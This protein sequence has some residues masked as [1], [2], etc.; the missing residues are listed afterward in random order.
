M[1]QLVYVIL[2][3]MFPFYAHSQTEIGIEFQLYPTGLIPGLRVDQ[4]ISDRTAMHLRLGYQI[5]DHRDL[6]VQDDET[7]SGYGLSIGTNHY[8]S[9]SREKWF[10]GLRA[11]LWL[12]SIDWINEDPVNTASGTTDITVLQPTALAGYRIPIGQQGFITPSIAFGFEWNVKTEGEPTGEG[13]ILL[14]GIHGGL[15]L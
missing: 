6:G 11:D 3:M 10:W 2:L 15:R 5:I 13:A 1:K 4:Y 12:N 8:F 9:D 7:G 14:I